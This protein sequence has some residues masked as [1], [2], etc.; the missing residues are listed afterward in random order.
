MIRALAVAMR[1]GLL[2]AHEESLPDES[3]ANDD[4]VTIPKISGEGEWPW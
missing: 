2:E 4:D 1:V 3:V